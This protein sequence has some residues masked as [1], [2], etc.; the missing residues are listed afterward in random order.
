MVL[1]NQFSM[2]SPTVKK[3]G[4][5]ED[6]MNTVSNSNQKQFLFHHILKP[7]TELELTS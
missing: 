7:Y 1:T 6:Q 3:A 4:S 2:L 5:K